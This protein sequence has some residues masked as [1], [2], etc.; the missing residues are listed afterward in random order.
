MQSTRTFSHA[1]RVPAR[2]VRF[3]PVWI[4]LAG[5]L[6]VAAAGSA[7]LRLAVVNGQSMQPTLQPG[8]PLL[9]AR[10]RR[11]DA[12]LQK[13]ELVLVRLGGKVCVKRI[14]AL[15]GAMFWTA[16]LGQGDC[17]V[18]DPRQPISTWRRRYPVLTYHQIRVPEHH[19]FVV[20]ENCTSMD[21]RQLGPVPAS[22][23]I[24]RVVFPAVGPQPAPDNGV[25]CSMPP[26]ERHGR[27]S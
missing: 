24:G 19:V 23:V 8:Q 27:R 9:Y 20:G 13:G 6:A 14:L 26:L 16:D 3:R 10:P 2:I 18:L 25:Y 1:V 12:P 15:G 17:L 22:A 21:S 7:P 5:L 11:E 4:L